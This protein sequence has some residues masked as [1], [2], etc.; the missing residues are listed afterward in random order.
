MCG[1]DAL[2]RVELLLN[3]DGRWKVTSRRTD[4]VVAT[5]SRPSR[6]AHPFSRNTEASATLW[7]VE[8]DDTAPLEGVLIGVSAI[9]DTSR[10][11]RLREQNRLTSYFHGL[12]GRVSS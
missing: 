5:L 8:G 7:I 3:N 1:T 6:W 11:A 9:L 2:D 12:A 4:H 10:W